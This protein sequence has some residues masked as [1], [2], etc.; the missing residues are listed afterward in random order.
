MPVGSLIEGIGWISVLGDVV[1][2]VVV[3]IVAAGVLSLYERIGSGWPWSSDEDDMEANTQSVRT[4]HIPSSVGN[5]HTPARTARIV[6]T[7]QELE[8]HLSHLRPNDENSSS[9]DSVCSSCRESVNTSS[10]NKDERTW[11]SEE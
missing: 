11:S 4:G 6:P 5:I 7:D 10:E 2:D 1:K 9:G 8:S 3:F